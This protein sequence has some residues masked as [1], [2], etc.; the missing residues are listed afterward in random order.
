M[1]PGWGTNIT[2][3]GATKGWRGDILCRAWN[4]LVWDQPLEPSVSGFCLQTSRPQESHV[5]QCVL[6]PHPSS[7]PSNSPTVWAALCLSATHRWTLRCPAFW[8]SQLCCCEHVAY[9]CLD[10]VSLP[11]GGHPQK[12]LSR[13]QTPL[14]VISE[15]LILSPCGVWARGQRT[16]WGTTVSLVASPVRADRPTRV[17]PT[18]Q[19]G[20][21]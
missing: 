5:L 4:G 3:C 13:A 8:S 7:H 15:G 10:V 19:M 17:E 2:P 9:I 21:L 20:A 1:T 14:D 16:P 18:E 12:E 11:L 6:V